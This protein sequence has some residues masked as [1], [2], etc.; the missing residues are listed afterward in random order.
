ML[1]NT[2][3]KTN[4][5]FGKTRNMFMVRKTFDLTCNTFM[6]STLNIIS[7]DTYVKKHSKILLG[8]T[9]RNT[10]SKNIEIHLC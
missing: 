8:F 1:R 6:V 2:F 4:N 7:P 10:L 3:G 5:T 9:L